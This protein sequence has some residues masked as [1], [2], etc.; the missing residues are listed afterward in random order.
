MNQCIRLSLVGL[1]GLNAASYTDAAVS[2]VDFEDIPLAGTFDNGAG[3][4]G[5]FT[6]QGVDFLNHYDSDFGSWDGFAISRSTDSTTSG[7]GNQY[8]AWPGSGHAGSTIYAVG[9]EN[10]FD[11]HRPTI[12]FGSLVDM[13]L[14]GGAYIT[15]TTY[16]A[17]SMRDGDGFTDPF[18]GASGNEADW[19]LLTITGFSGTSETGSQDFY[20]ADYRFADNSQDYIVDDWTWVDF[21]SLGEVDRI[22][23]SLSGSDVG[24]FGLNTPAYFA[25]DNLS[26]PEPGMTMLA[27]LGGLSLNRRKRK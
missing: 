25:M 14:G 15:N 6:S 10:S 19:F 27:L 4:S 1:I 23:F 5:K 8:S 12:E 21:S 20:L 16:A 24:A 2:A 22:E 7:F 17:L 9:Y 26:V 3:G 13:S 18:G 11:G